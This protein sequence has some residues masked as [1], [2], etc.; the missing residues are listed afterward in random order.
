[1]TNQNPLAGEVE[2]YDE[3]TYKRKCECGLDTTALFLY[4]PTNG[5]VQDTIKE[6]FFRLEKYLDSEIPD[7]YEY[8]PIVCSPQCSNM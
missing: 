8:K 1:M 4:L 2:G 3:S 6:K 7:G 5:E